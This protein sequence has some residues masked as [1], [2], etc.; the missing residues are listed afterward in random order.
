MIV[1]PYLYY[2]FQPGGLPILVWRTDM[3]SNDLLGF[4]IPTEVTKLGGT[5]LLSTSG[6]LPPASSKAVRTSACR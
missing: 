4:V 6:S 1:S 2:A 5:N 3:F